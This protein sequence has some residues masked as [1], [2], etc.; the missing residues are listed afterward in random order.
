M[1]EL[2]ILDYVLIAFSIAATWRVYNAVHPPAAGAEPLAQQP[3]QTRS[4]P[5]PGP[6]SGPDR[7]ASLSQTL[8][9]IAAACR[10]ALRHHVERLGEDHANARRLARGLAA[11]D[12]IAIDPDRPEAL[13]AALRQLAERPALA[14]AMGENGKWMVD[15]TFRYEKFTDRFAHLMWRHLGVARLPAAGSTLAASPRG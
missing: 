3:A 12:G 15:E 11:I 1:N 10:Y 4:G 6:A 2:N 8:K 9:R 5:P 14:K 7:D 13:A